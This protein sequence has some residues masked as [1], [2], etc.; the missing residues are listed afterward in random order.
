MAPSIAGPSRSIP[1]TPPVP[2]ARAKFAPPA[3]RPRGNGVGMGG[4]WRRYTDGV[5]LDGAEQDARVVRTLAP[6]RETH[7]CLP[8]CAA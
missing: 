3:A 1:A 6:D 2:T 5:P 4:A 7:A 8:A